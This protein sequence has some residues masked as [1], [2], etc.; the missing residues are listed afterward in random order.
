METIVKTDI[1]DW[2]GGEPADGA[3]G[4]DGAAVLVDGITKRYADH[5]ALAD[6]SL[7]VPAGSVL[8]LLGPNGPARR[9]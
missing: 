6:V 9:P 2:T 3:D 7:Q 5:T 8:S 4:A 1:E